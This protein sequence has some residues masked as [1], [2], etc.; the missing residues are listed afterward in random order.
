MVTNVQTSEGVPD[1]AGYSLPG[2]TYRIAAEENRRLCNAVAAQVA[3]DGTAHPIYCYIATQAG[4]GLS[5]DGLLE[6]CQFDAADGPLLGSTEVTFSGVLMTDVTYGVGGEIVDL[7]RKTSKKIGV[8]DMLRY[9][10]RMTTP[11]GESVLECV[12]TWILP[13][14][15]LHVD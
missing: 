11:G 13:R 1:V 10:L 9:R 7:T 6:K 8:V 15:N 14:R 3:G 4:M 5:V 2:G 12:N